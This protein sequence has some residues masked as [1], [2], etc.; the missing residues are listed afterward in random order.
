MEHKPI[1]KPKN[2]LC[3]LWCNPE[4]STESTIVDL[5]GQNCDKILKIKAEADC[6]SRTELSQ[7]QTYVE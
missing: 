3:V 6:T 5:I 2:P 1:S 7:P 4:T